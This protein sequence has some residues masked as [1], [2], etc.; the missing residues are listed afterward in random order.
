MKSIEVGTN[1]DLGNILLKK[2]KYH[3][4]FGTMYYLKEKLRLYSEKANNDYNV[5]ESPEEKYYLCIRDNTDE[6]RKQIDN[7]SLELMK[8][9]PSIIKEVKLLKDGELYIKMSPSLGRTIPQNQNLY[10]TVDI[11]ALFLNFN[12]KAFLQ[13]EVATFVGV[14][15]NVN[16]STYDSAFGNTTG[17]FIK[18]ED[19]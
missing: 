4:A 18:E 5:W 16:L 11:F 9:N 6:W 3:N 1:P 2:N 15:F 13:I 12:D 14:P 17:N 7:V 10:I 19:N 8:Q